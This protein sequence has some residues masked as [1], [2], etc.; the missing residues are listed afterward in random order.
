MYMSTAPKIE[1]ANQIHV[2]GPIISTH[3]I[4]TTHRFLV[5]YLHVVTESQV[6]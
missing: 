5:S 2:L 4:D 1:G 6:H 3:D